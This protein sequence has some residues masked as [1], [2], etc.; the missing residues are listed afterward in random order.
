VAGFTESSLNQQ[1]A[2]LGETI[3]IGHI[4]ILFSVVVPQH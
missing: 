2:R 4:V 3:H 1:C